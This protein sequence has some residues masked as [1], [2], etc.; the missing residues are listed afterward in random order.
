MKLKNRAKRL[1]VF[2]SV[3][4]VVGA[5]C[6]LAN[7]NQGISI[8]DIINQWIGIERH[9]IEAG[10][11]SGLAGSGLLEG[12]DAF[13]ESL[14]SF[15]D[16]EL[17]QIYRLVPLPFGTRP[18]FGQLLP[19]ESPGIYIL[20]EL[21]PSIRKA[22]LDEER[23]RAMLVSADITGAL[24]QIM[25]RDGNAQQFAADTYFTLLL[26][27]IVFIAFTAF[28]THFLYRTLARSLRR[29]EEGSSFSHAILLAQENERGRL[30]RELHDTVAQ[31]LRYL[32]LEMSK[33]GKTEEITLREKLCAEAAALQATLIGRVRGIC[34]NLVP[35]DFSFQG[36]PDALRR[37]CLD[38][39]KRTGLDCRI[40]IAENV[41]P[42]FLNEEKQL[43]VFRI[44]QEA[45]TNVEKHARAKEAI[46]I[47]RSDA[48]GGLYLSISDDGLGFT[49]AHR[50]GSLYQILDGSL[51]KPGGGM[52][53]GIRG[54]RERATL[55]GGHLTINSEGG[56]GTLIHLH[57]HPPPPPRLT[58]NK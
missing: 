51:D 47:L 30:Y 29:E 6:A 32:S 44:V 55:L 12:L 45:L 38:F 23:E 4:L 41:K 28:V 50:K 5:S 20:A 35:P 9:I 58:Q 36:L 26:I 17:Y 21:I 49:P 11:E 10:Q 13:Q 34:N 46:V 39:G 15:L 53:L 1:V 14:R 22:A 16:S 33:I 52:H 43:Q 42:S 31:D 54:M 57:L 3:Y 25:I 27:F 56:E 19:D 37:L 18:I 24:I 8:Q 40:N 2:T 7:Q 48:E